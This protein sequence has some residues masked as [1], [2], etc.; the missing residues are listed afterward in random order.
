MDLHLR[1]YIDAPGGLVH[2]EDLRLE[3]QPEGEHELL[4]IAA[5]QRHCP[6]SGAT[7]DDT[8][9]LYVLHGQPVHTPL[10]N[11]AVARQAEELR[12][13]HV[14]PDEHGQEESHGLPVFRHVGDSAGNG[15]PWGPGRKAFAFNEDLPRG[16]RSESED[17]SRELAPTCA[18]EAGHAEYLPLVQGE[19]DLL[20]DGSKGEI[21]DLECHV[22]RHAG[23]LRAGVQLNGPADH[24]SDELGFRRDALI[25]GADVLSV[26]Q[27]SYAIAQTENLLE[28]VGDV[29]DCNAAALK[30]GDQPEE[31]L[32]LRLRER[33][34]GLV[35]DEELRFLRDCPQNLHG[36]AISHAQGQEGGSRIQVHGKQIKEGTGPGV[37]IALVHDA[38]QARLT[39]CI[40]VLCNIE[41]QEDAELL[42]DDADPRPARVQGGVET[43]GPPI[44]HNGAFISALCSGKDAH[45]CALSRSVLPDHG[46]HLPG[47]DVH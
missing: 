27:H 26:P 18:H 6:L 21:P 32:H 14:C 19:A 46:V 42:V 16:W 29:Q 40:D 38:E 7:A 17:R 45:E 47:L 31:L 43:D 20:D 13:H 37:Q 22:T 1:S 5:A 4:L 41:I 12:G 3:R 28:L 36:L 24:H 23:L 33:G 11:P 25:D 34:G 39:V 30:L 35:K 2:D 44:E 15:L 9:A 8:D 10:I